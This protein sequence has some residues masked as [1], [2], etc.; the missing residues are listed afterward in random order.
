MPKK[1]HI[2][3]GIDDPSLKQAFILSFPKD[4]AAETNRLINLKK[5]QV[6]YLN[7]GEIY[8]YVTKALENMFD[9]H[10]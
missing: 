2:L 6:A 4:L 8:H 5:L 10:Q 1:F 3:Q 9:Q 7:L